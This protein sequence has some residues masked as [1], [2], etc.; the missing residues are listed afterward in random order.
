MIFRASGSHLGDTIWF[1]S[2][3]MDYAKTNP[4]VE[5]VLIHELDTQGKSIKDNLTDVMQVVDFPYRWQFVT[6]AGDYKQFNDFKV[7]DRI[8]PV[9]I[10][11]YQPD[12]ILYQF[13]GVSSPEKNPTDAEFGTIMTGLN[14]ICPSVMPVGKPLSL[15]EST[16]WLMRGKL[17]LGSDSGMANLCACVGKPMIIFTPDRWKYSVFRV[18]Y[19]SNCIATPNTPEKLI[20]D[21]K[22]FM[23]GK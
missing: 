8:Q 11:K 3:I 5:P 13:D 6:V 1:V 2:H 18:G 20:A 9:P 10:M 4:I 16:E 17:F 22:E 23:K 21:V 15:H 14:S 19:P 12:I 7:W